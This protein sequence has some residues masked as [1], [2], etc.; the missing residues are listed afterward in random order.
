[1]I[2]TDNGGIRTMPLARC[3]IH[4]ILL[5]AFKVAE[6]GNRIVLDLRNGSYIEDLDSGDYIP[7]YAKNG[8]F[9]LPFKKVAAKALNALA[10]RV[11]GNGGQATLP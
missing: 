6:A 9:V 3:N 2:F 7:V 5:S 4:K 8:V 1:V 10:A 11:S